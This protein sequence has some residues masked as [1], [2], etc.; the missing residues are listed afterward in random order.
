MKR[1]A[2]A[3]ALLLFAST[4]HAQEEPPSPPDAPAVPD[5]PAPQPPPAQ[6]LAPVR[7]GREP[8]LT[9][10]F[11][12]PLGIWIS[13]YIQAQYENSQLS[14]DQ[15]QQGGAPLNDDRFL[16][17]RARL[18]VDRAW[19][20]ADAAIEIDGNT[21]HGTSIG[22]RRAE[23]S[24]LYRDSDPEKAPPIRVTAGLS[25]I[26]FGHELVDSPRNRVFMERSLGNLALFPGEPDIGVR[27]SGA[28]GFF[29]YAVAVQNGEPID[30]RPG[31]THQ[32]LNAAKDVIGRV[33]IDT[34]IRMQ[35]SGADELRFTGGASFLV[36]RGFHPGTDATKNSVQWRDLNENGILDAG[37]LTALPGSA[38]VPSQ[39]FDRWAVG[40]D[41]GLALT[42]K[43]GR[44]HL[45]GEA[46][47]A[48]NADRGVNVADPI[49]TGSDVR[50]LGWYVA[51]VQEI[52]HWGIIG[53]RADRYDPNADFLDKRVGKL[54]PSDASITTLSP[55]V[56]ITLPDRVRVLFQ[57]DAI[58]DKL[59]RD[60]RGVPTDLKNDQLTIRVQGEL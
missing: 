42:T 58:L 39:N 3:L 22:L 43:Y 24:L 20:W 1:A 30:D 28:L 14:E 2:A 12:G 47:L 44:T 55:L 25:E 60:G 57:Y 32:D 17:R 36:G 11:L 45:Y 15:L 56:G 21:N 23:I 13:G 51:V 31:R 49:A 18:R 4:V 33:G 8:S 53:F 54:V 52:T 48:Q 46:F 37:E 34:P 38:A 9:K 7:G 35:P 29:R 59:A 50:E 19:K 16:I 10:G 26:P 5:A 40:I 27:A 6:D 41:L